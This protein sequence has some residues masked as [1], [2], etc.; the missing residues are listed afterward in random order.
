MLVQAATVE[1]QVGIPPSLQA[2]EQLPE[3]P[4]G[5]EPWQGLWRDGDN[6]A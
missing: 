3:I 1:H 5:F 6:K 2:R 4:A